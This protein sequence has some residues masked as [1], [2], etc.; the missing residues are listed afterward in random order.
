MVKV[1]PDSAARSQPELHLT[2]ARNEFVSFQV[3]LQGG[4]T[5][6]RGVRASLA[7]LEGP[8]RISGTDV[9]LYREEFLKTTKATVA[10][11]PVGRWPDGLVPDV[12][13]IAG[14]QR[15]AFPMDVP[16]G[17]ARA[18]WVDVH[19]PMDAPPGEYH[20]VVAV[21]ADNSSS[22]EV[23]V[24][25]TV[26][27]ATLPSTPSLATAFLL[28]RGNVCRA[29]T[30]NTTCSPEQ[31]KQLLSRYQRMALEHRITLANAIPQISQSWSAFDAAWGPFLDGT[32]PSRL[33]GAK[34]TS[35]QFMGAR[36]AQAI[37]DFAAHFQERGWLERAYDYVG[38][39]PP[40]GIS[41]ETLSQRAAL[42]RRVAPGLR[43]LVTTN[44]REMESHKLSDLIDLAV[45]VV[46]FIDGTQQPF[47][48]DQRTTYQA[49]LSKPKREL[50]LYQSCMSHGCAYGTNAAENLPNAGWPSYMVDRSAAKG[51]A[52]EWVSFLEGAKGEL[53][54]ETAEMLGSAWTNQYIYNGNGDGT[55]F[56]AGKPSVIGGTTDVP[57]ASI[58]L[59]L[60]RLGVQDYE[61]LKAVSDAGDPDFA[62]KV[63]RGL[64]PSASHVPDDGAAFEKARLALIDRY[65]ELTSLHDS[66]STEPL[67]P[68]AS[69]PSP[70]SAPQGN[71]STGPQLPSSSVL[72]P[73]DEQQQVGCSAGGAT[74]SAGGAL[75]VL[76][77]LAIERRRVH[78]RAR[79]RS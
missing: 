23:Q 13:E 10:G 18:I 58:R 60:I 9:T 33:P 6:L 65:L 26:V 2:A 66:P 28:Y 76:T 77:W 54:Y 73:D 15:R 59:K 25:L 34:M 68:S 42:T 4:D 27:D 20:G 47:Q 39:E 61:W 48:G 29:H 30:G 40:Y 55:L 31:L 22:S 24:Q 11:T 43:T 56:Y 38:D 71:P 52:M 19:V 32:A 12:D 50:W 7:G 16:A 79:R 45:P 8:A 44:S 69:A 5:G 21:T 70:G 46:N 3:G 78:A 63:A 35:A 17:E 51:R 62:R 53:Y 72:Q 36:T 64:I 75:L 14:E 74:A 37:A 49:F 67:N 41:F 1:R 57:V